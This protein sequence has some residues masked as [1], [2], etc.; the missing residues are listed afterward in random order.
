[1]FHTMIGGSL[2]SY[3]D[4]AIVGLMLGTRLFVQALG[5]VG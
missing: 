4:A 5:L 1:M 2:R 3:L